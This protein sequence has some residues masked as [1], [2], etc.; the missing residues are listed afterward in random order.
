MDVCINCGLEIAPGEYCSDNECSLKIKQQSL[1]E[2][3]LKI[4]STSK[5]LSEDEKME[6]LD[7]VAQ[8]QEALS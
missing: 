2:K 8:L 5:E 1:Q 4:T 3:L 7:I 6:V